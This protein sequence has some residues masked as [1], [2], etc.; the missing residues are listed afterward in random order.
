MRDTRRPLADKVE[1]GAPHLAAFV[2][3]IIGRLPERIRRKALQGAFDRARD[4]FN[5]GDLEVV[6]ALFAPDV[7]Y[8]PP[9][10]LHEGAVLRG[11]EAVFAFWRA[12]LSRYDEN[13]IVNMS[14][15]EASPE[16]FVRLARLHHHSNVTG[17][18]LDYSIVQTT[19]LNRGQVTRQVNTLVSPEPSTG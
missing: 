12:V 9:P 1:V 6:F 3:R 14:V 18:T 5:R 17:E 2:A 15:D 11:R 8:G 7:E 13:S 19:E 16:R 4:A 10:P